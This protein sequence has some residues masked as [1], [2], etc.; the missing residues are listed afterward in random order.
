M[1]GCSM[2][3][4]VMD[5]TLRSAAGG[6]VSQISGWLPWVRDRMRR[7]WSG[8]GGSA[9]AQRIRAR[10]ARRPWPRSAVSVPFDAYVW[11]LTDPETSV[12]DGAAGLGAA[13]AHAR[14]A[15]GSSGSSTS[16]RSTAG[17][18]CP[19][20]AR[21]DAPAASLMW[22]ELLRVHGVTDIASAVFRD[23]Y[24]CWA[25]LDLWR[26]GGPFTGRRTGRSSTTSRRCSPTHLRRCAAAC[27]EDRR[28]GR[29]P[30][31]R[32]GRPA[33]RRRPA[34]PRPDPADA[35]LSGPAA[36]RPGTHPIP[37][38][39]YNVAAQ[40][41]PSRPASTRNRPWPACTWPPAGG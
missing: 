4:V 23:R 33:A 14:P 22:R 17:P 30:R 26:V 32:P 19:G 35:R 21:L 15:R 36:A 12:G 27:F 29:V 37:A 24:G 25:F 39:A 41:S 20:P 16:P 18:A 6:P 7:L 34:R 10:C 5:S 28:R 11:P 8:C 13:V 40:L 31:P 9:A 2:R 1:I 38:T 3:S